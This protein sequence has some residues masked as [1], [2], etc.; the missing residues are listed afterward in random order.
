MLLKNGELLNSFMALR[1]IK[2]DTKGIHIGTALSIKN[3][4]DAMSPVLKNFEEA[5]DAVREK[6][7]GD[8]NDA[9]MKELMELAELEVE[10]SVV[11]LK[12]SQIEHYETPRV[13]FENGT[14][15]DAVDLLSEKLIEAS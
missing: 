1:A 2:N 11:P 5:R 12:L 6:F 7:N 9:A 14:T 4:L 10:V 13:Q 15:F 3:L 8:L